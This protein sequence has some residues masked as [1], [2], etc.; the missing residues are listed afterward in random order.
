MSPLETSN[1]NHELDTPRIDE[2]HL[3]LKDPSS[4]SKINSAYKSMT[5][6]SE[7]QVD[8]GPP[9]G[10]TPP[11]SAEMSVAREREERAHL[12]KRKENKNDRKRYFKSWKR[13]K[14]KS[15]VVME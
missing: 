13:E 12:K 5:I 9:E 3:P 10:K 11:F 15:Q 4:F 1:S 7:Q 2:N 14:S 8:D 6:N